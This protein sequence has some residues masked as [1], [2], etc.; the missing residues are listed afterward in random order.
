MWGQRALVDHL[1]TQHDLLLA[2]P[3]RHLDQRLLLLGVHG[4]PSA[5]HDAP[6]PGKALE[7][8]DATTGSSAG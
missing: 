2:A 3:V 8:C 6:K 4:V 5:W 1:Q 7:V